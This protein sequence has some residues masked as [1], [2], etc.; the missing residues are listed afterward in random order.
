[1]FFFYIFVI[2]MLTQIVA[3]DDLGNI[4]FLG[5]LKWQNPFLPTPIHNLPMIFYD[6]STK[7]WHPRG[8]F[9]S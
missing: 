4:T 3:I 8:H 1:M 2:A 7:G 6:I 9:T 5:T